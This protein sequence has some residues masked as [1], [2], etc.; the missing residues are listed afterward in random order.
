MGSRSALHVLM[1]VPNVIG[2]IRV[3]MGVLAFVDWRN[4]QRFSVLYAVSFVL[5]AA[6]GYAA[7][8]YDQSSHFGSYLDMITDRIGTLALLVVTGISAREV[9]ELA[10][11]EEPSA[12]VRQWHPVQQPF[13]N[14]VVQPLGLAAMWL[15]VPLLVLLDGFSHWYQMLAGLVSQGSH[16]Q[17]S[18]NRFLRWYY[19]RPVLTIVCIFNELFILMMFVL[20]QQSLGKEYDA[21]PLWASWEFPWIM[22]GTLL[23]VSFP[24]FVLKQCVS[25]Q[26]I[27]SSHGILLEGLNSRSTKKATSSS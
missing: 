14:L 10:R 6:D 12:L 20:F 17:A 5:D 26:Q 23:V 3:L 9:S 21:A 11:M 27:V 2:Y 24:V 15:L 18:D 4:M 7:R 1:Y 16:K 19:W 22:V 8:K 13:L 25:V